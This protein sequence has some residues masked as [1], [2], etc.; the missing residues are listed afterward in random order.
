MYVTFIFIYLH[1]PGMQIK[2]V[3]GTHVS[4]RFQY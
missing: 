2:Q 3:F 1:I 4:P